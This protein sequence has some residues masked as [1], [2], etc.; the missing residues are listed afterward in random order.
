MKLRWKNGINMQIPRWMNVV[1]EWKHKMKNGWMILG[2]RF[3]DL[4]NLTTTLKMQQP[5]TRQKIMQQKGENQAKTCPFQLTCVELQWLTRRHIMK[6]I[7]V[8]NKMK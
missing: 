4:S 8:E 3:G 5:C 6:G 1:G 2:D 7:V